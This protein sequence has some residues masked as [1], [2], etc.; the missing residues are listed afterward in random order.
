MGFNDLLIWVKTSLMS[1]KLRA[2]LTI[3]GFATGMA[4]VV[5]MN[6]IGESLRMYV[7]QE[8]TQ[9]GSNII[10]ITPGKTETF[11][12]GGLL[13]TVRPL[14]LADGVYL[15]K[16]K[17]I[18]FVVPVV[19]GNAKVKA[20]N[21][22]RYIDIIGV[23]SH[24]DK[25]WKLDVA[26]GKF[27]PNDDLKSPRSFAVLGATLKQELFGNSIAL[28]KFI[29]VG[30]QRF[31]VIGVLAQKGQ[32][33]GQDLD[34][35]VYIPA[36][37][38]LQLFNRNS[39]MELDIFYQPGLTASE[40]VAQ[41]KPKLINRHGL[42]DFTIITQDDMLSSMDKILSIIKMAGSA[43]GMISLLVGSVGIAT[44]MTITVTE[45][46]AEIGLLRALGFSENQVKRLFLTEAVCLAVVSG[47]IGYLLVF[48]LML[49][50]KLALPTVPVD[51]NIMV[52]IGALL[53][54]ALIGLIAGIYPARN[55]SRLTPIDALRAE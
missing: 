2:G 7:L 38:A 23:N 14:T 3:A 12:M 45:R 19:A 28:G 50:A 1:Q 8:F 10:A 51:I 6:S 17:H 25:A 44:I 55:A 40:V 35:V 30:S 4:A 53:V 16:Q 42:E 5:L 27:L 15:N 46:T 52:L 20:H 41:I 43:L 32:F 11:G 13:K 33:M 49:L 26:Q 48:S 21:R 22:A 24:A 39:L 37:T 36:A 9:F 29:H 54:S 34:D 18:N 31:K 47:F